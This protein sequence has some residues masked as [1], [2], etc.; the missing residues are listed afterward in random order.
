M[1]FTEKLL[2]ITLGEIIHILDNISQ[3]RDQNDQKYVRYFASFDKYSRNICK[4]IIKIFVDN[5]VDVDKH[6]EDRIRDENIPLEVDDI[7][8]L[9]KITISL[10]KHNKKK[11]ISRKFKYWYEYRQGIYKIIKKYNKFLIRFEEKLDR[12]QIMSKLEKIEN[13]YNSIRASGIGIM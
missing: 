9:F 12:L 8:N 1:S 11:I 13:D 5:K 4:I 3:I 7:K 10:D 2:K 6:L